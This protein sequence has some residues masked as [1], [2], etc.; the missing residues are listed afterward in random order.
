MK[1]EKTNHIGSYFRILAHILGAGQPLNQFSG[2][3]EQDY[4]QSEKCKYTSGLREVTY[5]CL[6]QLK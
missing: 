6:F 2:F 4:M 1:R 5:P 3:R